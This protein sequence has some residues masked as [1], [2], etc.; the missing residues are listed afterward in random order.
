MK[1]SAVPREIKEGVELIDVENNATGQLAKLL[2]METG[3]G[4]EKWILKYDG[5]PFLPEELARQIEEIKGDG[6]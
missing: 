3:I 2:K 5:R 6:K 1:K 4:I